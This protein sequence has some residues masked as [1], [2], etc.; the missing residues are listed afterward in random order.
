MV[1]GDQ[2]CAGAQVM[3]LNG[4]GEGEQGGAKR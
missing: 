3:L 2:T 4:Q 1:T